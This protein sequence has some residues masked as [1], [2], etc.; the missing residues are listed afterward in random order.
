MRIAPWGATV[1]RCGLAMTGAGRSEAALAPYS[2]A[3]DIYRQ[4]PGTELDQRSK[5]TRLNS[6]H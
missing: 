3:L 5:S 1:K 4:L 2:L 6:S